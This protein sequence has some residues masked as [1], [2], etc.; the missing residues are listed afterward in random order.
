M[1]LVEGQKYNIKL[2]LYGHTKPTIYY[3]IYFMWI[4]EMDEDSK[5]VCDCC[6]KSVMKYPL[7]FRL[8][9]NGA[10]YDECAYKYFTDE[11]VIGSSCL[12]KAS[13]TIAKSWQEPRV[14][15]CN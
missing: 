12:Q 10:T 3:G 15:E 5:I 9:M 7:V 4:G 2:T 13:I 1:R 14:V 11:I 6:G 8:P